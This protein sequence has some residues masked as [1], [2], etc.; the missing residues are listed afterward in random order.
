[1]F[2]QTL[3]S[4][5]NYPVYYYLTSLFRDKHIQQSVYIYKQKMI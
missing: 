4:K 1:M 2:L 5:F 3:Y